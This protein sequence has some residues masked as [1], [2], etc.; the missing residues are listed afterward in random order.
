MVTYHIQDLTLDSDSEA[1][2][3]PKKRSRKEVAARSITNV[4]RERI[5]LIETGYN[6]IRISALTDNTKTWLNKRD[7]LAIFS[8]DALDYAIKLHNVD[9]QTVG[10]VKHFEQDL[11]RTSF[12]L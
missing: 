3:P 8:E 7:D 1:S 11:V 12:R 5:P 10:P 6:F 4:D 9:P 2:L